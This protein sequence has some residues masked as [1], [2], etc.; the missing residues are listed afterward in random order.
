M[1]LIPFATFE[2]HLV[3]IIPFLVAPVPVYDSLDKFG[4][5]IGR[6][7]LINITFEANPKPH[8]DWIINQET[9]NEASTD[10]TGRIEAEAVR[11]LVRFYILII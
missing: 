3:Y 6:L 4:Y 5:Q 10:R 2:Q 9:I 11:D 8:I 7:G 1:R